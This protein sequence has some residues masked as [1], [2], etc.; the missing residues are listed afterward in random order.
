[1]F[2]LGEVAQEHET[3]RWTVNGRSKEEREVDSG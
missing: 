1:M 3:S 2:M